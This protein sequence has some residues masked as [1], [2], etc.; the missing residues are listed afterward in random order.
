VRIL[1]AAPES[2]WSGFL[3]RLEAE[4][5]EHE[6]QALEDFQ[7]GSLAGFDIVIPTMTRIE[8]G[9]IA[10]ADRLKLIQQVGAGLEGVDVDAARDAGIAV[11][12][13]PSETSGNADSV[14]EMGIYLMIALARD[15]R[16]MRASMERGVIGTPF[17]LALKG[18]T[19]GVLGL[20]GI[21]RALVHRLRPF[22]TRLFGIKRH[23]AAAAGRELGLHWAGT[24]DDLDTL[25]AASDF[26]VLALPDSSE[27]HGLIGRRELAAMKRGSFLVNLGRGGL[28]ERDALLEALESGI[29]AGAGLDVFWAEPPDS[30]DP[31]FEQNVIATPHVAGAT[32]ISAAGILEG[33]SDNIRRLSAGEQILHRVC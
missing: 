30:S 27:T 31:V 12:N 33:V 29:I 7:A 25:L 5:P 16:Q 19:V 1:F 22:G 6:F 14:A 3:G 20:G 15:A 17:G 2:A 28:V 23:D 11:A 10:T 21:G 32:D 18:K 4:N 13:V 26:V 9:H 8:A 24:L